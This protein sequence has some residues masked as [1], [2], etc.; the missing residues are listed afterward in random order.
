MEEPNVYHTTQAEPGDNTFPLSTLT[1]VSQQLKWHIIIIQ[2]NSNITLT[3]APSLYGT[4]PCELIWYNIMDPT[5]VLDNV[6]PICC[7]KGC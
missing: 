2:N 6:Q 1:Y 7:Y 5:N 4:I 3:T